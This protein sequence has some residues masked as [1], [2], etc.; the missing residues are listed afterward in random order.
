MPAISR[1]LFPCSRQTLMAAST[2]SSS[3]TLTTFPLPKTFFPKATPRVR[4]LLEPIFSAGIPYRFWY[5]D[6]VE[7]DTFSSLA[8]CELVSFLV[9]VSSYSFDSSMATLF[10]SSV[11]LIACLRD[12]NR[13]ISFIWKELLSSCQLILPEDLYLPC[14]NIDHH[15]FKKTSEPYS[16]MRYKEYGVIM[17]NIKKYKEV[18]HEALRLMVIKERLLL[19]YE[20]YWNTCAETNQETCLDV[21]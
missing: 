19:P 9:T 15:F 12:P 7:R 8:I 21:V 18:A 17:K 10:K 3:V 14:F 13:N 16:R 5:F 2:F 11:D 4:F 1:K 6:T 20:S